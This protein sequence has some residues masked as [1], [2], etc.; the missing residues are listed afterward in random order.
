MMEKFVALQNKRNKTSIVV[1]D[2]V[3]LISVV[4]LHIDLKK[5][6]YEITF[7]TVL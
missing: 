7:I 3:L 2:V 5:P 1:L 4:V 6:K